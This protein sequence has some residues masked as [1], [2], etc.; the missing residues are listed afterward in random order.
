MP[1]RR[2]TSC[3]LTVRIIRDDMGLEAQRQ[4]VRAYCEMLGPHLAAVC[5]DSGVW[6]GKPLGSRLAGNRL[7]TEARRSRSVVVV[8]RLDRLFRS[9]ADAAQTIADF[10]RRGIRLVAIAEGFDIKAH[11][12]CPCFFGLFK[13]RRAA[14]NRDFG[15]AEARRLVRATESIVSRR[16]A[17][18]PVSTEQF[19]PRTRSPCRIG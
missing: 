12:E 9:V 16:S 8:A 5:G 14:K 4:R 18:S 19:P 7:L 15:F 3:I 10:D 13:G 11:P 1:W 6:G 17:M 2:R